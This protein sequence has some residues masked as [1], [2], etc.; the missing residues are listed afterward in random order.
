MVPAGGSGGWRSSQRYEMR[1]MK[2]TPE[3]S[4][5]VVKFRHWYT[6]R[7]VPKYRW[8]FSSQFPM[9]FLFR[10]WHFDGRF[11]HNFSWSEWL[12]WWPDL[13]Q[14]WGTWPNSR[15]GSLDRK[16]SQLSWGIC[17]D[18]GFSCEDCAVKWCE[19]VLRAL[20]RSMLGKG[21][22]DFEAEKTPLGEAVSNL[23]VWLVSKFRF[24][25]W[26]NNG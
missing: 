26:F 2:L 18:K 16:V 6:L 9:C 24:Q 4:F 3:S 5:C 17:G 10:W 15:H 11:V 22:Q 12:K 14:V 13:V 19:T 23:S 20:R 21:V 25:F 1:F 7:K 8:C